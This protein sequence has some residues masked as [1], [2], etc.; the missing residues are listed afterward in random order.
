MPRLRLA[1]FT[2]ALAALPAGPAFAHESHAG[3]V[4][5]SWGTWYG[6]WGNGWG[7]W[8]AP[9]VTVIL[10]PQGQ[11]VSP[12]APPMDREGWLRECR[13][14]L[15]DNGVGGAVIGGVVGGV[16]GHELAGRHDKVLGTV[17]GAGVG[18]A[19][20]AAID[21]TEDAGRARDRCEAMLEGGPGYPPPSYGAYGYGMPV[22]MVPVMMVPAPGQVAKAPCTETVTTEYVPEEPRRSRRIPPRAPAHSK[23]VP[24][25][26][27][28][29][30]KN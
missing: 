13:H 28:K 5:R 4:A 17:A 29:R 19:A 3:E 23:R 26:P 2:L 14:R 24:I 15:G 18:A 16:A 30:V 7:G 6:G 11:L 20:G 21:R 9:D 12:E 22:M 1:A 25:I 27:D 10:P 8:S